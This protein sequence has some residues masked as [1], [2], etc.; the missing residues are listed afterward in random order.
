MMGDFAAL[1]NHSD[2]MFSRWEAFGR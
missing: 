1:S 2:N